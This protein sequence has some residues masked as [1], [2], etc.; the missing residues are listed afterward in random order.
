MWRRI[1]ISCFNTNTQSSARHCPVHTL[2]LKYI[3]QHIS[4]YA[5]IA[6]HVRIIT[7][8]N[9]PL[10]TSDTRPPHTV[11]YLHCLNSLT[12]R[13]NPQGWGNL[14]P[15]SVL[16]AIGLLWT[17]IAEVLDVK[18]WSTLWHPSCS[19]AIWC[20]A[21]SEQRVKVALEV[22]DR[23]LD[24]QTILLY[25]VLTTPHRELL[26][27]YSMERFPPPTTWDK[28]A[29]LYSLPSVQCINL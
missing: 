4:K 17:W 15:P 20:V 26:L 5:M 22:V 6:H 11:T 10:T 9:L 19:E 7:K 8:F 27:M 12:L 21:W 13:E 3:Q 16:E 14:P 23:S 18:K 25:C 1:Q 29:L 2:P 28:T 24:G